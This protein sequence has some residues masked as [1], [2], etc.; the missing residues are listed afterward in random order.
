MSSRALRKAQRQIEA[1]SGHQSEQGADAETRVDERDTIVTQNL[2]AMLG[3]EDEE[4]EEAQD[5]PPDEQATENTDLTKHSVSKP[6]SKRKRKGKSKASDPPAT[7]GEHFDEVDMALRSLALKNAGTTNPSSQ[8]PTEL[9]RN[10]EHLCKLLS[11]NTQNLDATN[12]MRRLFGRVILDTDDGNNRAIAGGGRGRGGRGGL[13]GTAAGRRAGGTGFG[14]RKNAFIQGK[15]TWPQATGGGLGMEIVEK[16]EDGTVEYKFVHNIA[17]RDV[18]RQFFMCVESLDPERMIQ[19]L[20]HNPYHV[21]TLLQVHEIALAERD[22]SMAG[23]LLERALFSLGRS[24]HSTFAANLAQGKVRLD[25]RRA[26][27]RELW[28]AAWR[29]TKNLGRRGTWRTAFEWSKLLLALSPQEDPYCIGLVIDQLC[30]RAKQERELLG[31]AEN[32]VF[33]PQWVNYPNM[34][35]SVALAHDQLRQTEPARSALVAAIQ[36]FPWVVPR[37]LKELNVERIPPKLWGLEPPTQ[38]DR[39]LT[40]LYAV[41]SKDIWN[42][43][44]AT[45]LLME[46]A[47]EV[48]RMNDL[49]PSPD[50]DSLITVNQARHV[51]LEDT[52]AFISFLPRHFLDPATSPLDPFPP[53][54]NISPYTTTTA[55]TSLVEQDAEIRT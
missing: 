54:D 17:Y 2:F 35:F 46:A 1:D 29:Y 50:W 37:L 38:P 3:V 18:Q 28:L 9:V 30:L 45:S 12:E 49:S 44:E 33:A 36:K 39:L 13:A 26:E 31:L 24:S 42:T 52:P 8:F 7:T 14:L 43:P 40:E 20:A 41:R 15:D 27:N 25:F 23:D 11:I 6:K 16:K 22:H 55:D 4:E 51:L 48:S 19:L 5:E 47:E 53:A 34:A 32:P 21:A 10:S